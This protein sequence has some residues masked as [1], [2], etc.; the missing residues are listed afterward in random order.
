MTTAEKRLIDLYVANLE[1]I[2]EGFPYGV[3]RHRRSAMEAFH[4]S[5]L[6]DAK[7][8][9]YRY[10]PLAL[11][12]QGEYENYFSPF[13]QPQANRELYGDPS[14]Y[15]VFEMLNGRFRTPEALRV[16]ETG[17][18]CGSLRAA[19]SEYP[20]LIERCYNT[21]ACNAIDAL[22]ALNTAFAQDGFFLY[23]PDGISA[24]K[25]FYVLDE[26]SA[27]EA[28]SA[29]G[30]ALV[31]LGENTRV[32]VLWDTCSPGGDA[33]LFNRVGEIRCAVGS[34]LEWAEVQ[35]ADNRTACI[36]SHYIHQEASSRVRSTVITLDGGFFRNNLSAT[37]GGGGAE[38]EAYGL[39]LVHC[40]QHADNA[41]RVVHAVPDCLSFERYKGI[42]GAEGTVVFKGRVEVTPDAQ[43][44]RAFQENHNLLLADTGRIYTRPQLEI[45][46]D[47][48]KCS[49]GATT[50]RLDEEAVYYMRQRGISKEQAERLQMAGF[51]HDIIDCVGIA[52][53]AE[54]I[55]A[56]ALDKIGRI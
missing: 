44:T 48:V 41:L 20:D 7:D 45:Y 22:T 54:A 35:R 13:G 39:S 12:Y 55:E 9:H 32:S 40:G 18:V 14:H 11:L 2:E 36:S 53:A 26:F 38:F 34:Q 28:V 51:V 10:C 33:Y 37:L 56:R 21:L 25:P 30:R 43:R 42:A 49:H 5:G 31:V 23:V 19:A 15:E 3:N 52:A 27:S 8:E 47:D 6:P 17:I 4:L 29:Y 24:E 16:Y 1:L 50:G 46:A